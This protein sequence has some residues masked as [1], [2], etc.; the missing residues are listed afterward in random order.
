MIL[1]YKNNYFFQADH[2]PECTVATESGVITRESEAQVKSEAS[3][4]E[5]QVQSEASVSEAQVQSE[6]SASEAQVL[7]EA[8]VTEAST[9]TGIEVS[10]QSELHHGNKSTQH[11]GPVL[12]DKAI[13]C[14]PNTSHAKCQHSPQ[15]IN[16]STMTEFPMTDAEVSCNLLYA[17]PLKGMDPV[18]DEVELELEDEE[19]EDMEVDDCEYQPVIEDE[20]AEEEYY[21]CEGAGE[22]LSDVGKGVKER[23]FIVFESCLSVLF[24]F[25]SFCLLPCKAVISAKNGSCIKI[26]QVCKGGHTR[27]WHSQPLHNGLPLGN[28]SISQGIFYSGASQVKAILSMIHSNIC[29]ISLRTYHQLQRCYLVP[30]VTRVWDRYQANE[31]TLHQSLGDPLHLG[32]DARFDSR[33]YSAKYSSYTCTNLTNG[34]IVNVE[35]VQSNEVKSSPAMELEGLKR[36]FDFLSEMNLKVASLTTDRHASIKKYLSG[37]PTVK[38]WF[39]VWHVAKG[40]YKKVCELGKKRGHETVLQWAQSISNHVYWCAATSNGDPE[41]VRQKGSPF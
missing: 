21:E 18:I 4:S 7:T 3:V 41:L 9:P 12:Y 27:E 6:A 40:V 22:E 26:K 25:C 36:T 5:A 1:F 30:S 15:Q 39:D 11:C 31:L 10:T 32:G 13:S 20:D 16:V 33:G 23:K 19:E 29:T 28:M 2:Q 24:A 8:S 14:K 17:P 38:H 35:L 34:N 37:M